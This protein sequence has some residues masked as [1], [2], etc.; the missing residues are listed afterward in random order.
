M[1]KRRNDSMIEKNVLPVKLSKTQRIE[2]L[3]DRLSNQ[4]SML[5]QQEEL[6]EQRQQKLHQIGRRIDEPHAVIPKSCNDVEAWLQGHPFPSACIANVQK[7]KALA[8]ELIHVCNTY[9]MFYHIVKCEP[10]EY[11]EEKFLNK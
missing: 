5:R 2:I 3:Y 8:E 6:L 10:R 7:N 11:Y 9:E 1:K 4:I